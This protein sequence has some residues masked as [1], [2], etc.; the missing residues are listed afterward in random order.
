[1]AIVSFGQFDRK[2]QTKL[3]ENISSVIAIVLYRGLRYAR[4]KNLK[5]AHASGFMIVMIL[6]VLGL[7]AVFDS[8][9]YAN[10]PIPNLYSLHSWIGLAA[11]ILFGLQVTYTKFSQ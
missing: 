11:V 7:V 2:V 6:A 4:K 1:M 10:P 9:N 8:H 3:D 5:L